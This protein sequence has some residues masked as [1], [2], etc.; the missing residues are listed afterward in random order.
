MA[1]QYVKSYQDVLDH[2]T[3]DTNRSYLCTKKFHV[4]SYIMMAALSERDV[5]A[6]KALEACGAA[7]NSACNEKNILETVERLAAQRQGP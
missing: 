5:W 4:E 1:T 7:P 2:C 6:S 3:T